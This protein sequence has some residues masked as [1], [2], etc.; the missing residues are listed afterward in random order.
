[1][2]NGSIQWTIAAI[3]SPAWAKKVFPDAADEAEAVDKMW[4]AIY[5]ASRVDDND[6][7]E[8]WK[9]HVDNLQHKVDF[10]MKHNFKFMR[11]KNKLG[12][13]LEITLPDGHRWISCGEKAKTGYN[14][15]ANIPTEEVFS[16]PLKGGT[17]GIVYSTKPLVHMGDLIEDFWLKFKDGKVVEYFAKKN[18][19]LL[20]KLLT[21]HENADYL[22]E[23]ALVPFDSPI[24][25]SGILWYNTLYDENAS[26]HL[27][28]GRAYSTCVDGVDGK[29][30]EELN[31]MGIN[32][33]LTHEDFMIGSS[34]LEII[35]VTH[36]GKEISVFKNGNFAF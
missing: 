8:N 15:I 35:G 2:S 21:T 9:N 1:V 5:A 14:F 23:V 25:N 30:E 13:D 4:D 6:P 29:T 11:F 26:C 16:A 27:A 3:P 33:S 19:H 10:L 12:T 24:S 32:Q 17:N 34:D 22:G 36:D 28:V 7:I 31:A 20:E 18:Q